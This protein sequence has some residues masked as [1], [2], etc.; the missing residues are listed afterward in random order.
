MQGNK[1]HTTLGEL[2]NSEFFIDGSQQQAAIFRDS[3]FST[4][5]IYFVNNVET[6]QIKVETQNT[7]GEYLRCMLGPLSKEELEVIVPCYTSYDRTCY[8]EP[9][10]QVA[11]EQL[12]RLSAST[13]VRYSMNRSWFLKQLV[14][15][16]GGPRSDCHKGLGS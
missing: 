11:L 10:V 9:Q 6:L 4:V 8:D 14:S 3:Q 2:L 16:F 1:L 12:M 5:C 7:A 15:P 13:K